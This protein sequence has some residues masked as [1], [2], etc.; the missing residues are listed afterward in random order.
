MSD[1]VTITFEMILKP[2]MG[3]VVVERLPAMLDETEQRPGYRD[4]RV[5]RH[6]DNPDRIL[7][8]ETWDSEGHYRDYLAWR[9]SR[10]ETMEAILEAPPVM[11][12]WPTMVVRR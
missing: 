10:G 2:G 1:G 3:D 9:A 6:K 7:L 12:V 4:I 5:V 8:I 11:N